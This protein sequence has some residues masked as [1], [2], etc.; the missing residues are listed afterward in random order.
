LIRFIKKLFLPVAAPSGGIVAQRPLAGATPD[1]FHHSRR[2][3]FSFFGVG[4]VMLAKPDLFLPNRPSSVKEIRFE[5]EI[6][7]PLTAGL[8]K[9]F[10]ETYARRY[11]ALE[12]ALFFEIITGVVPPEAL[13]PVPAPDKNGMVYGFWPDEIVPAR[14]SLDDPWEG[15]LHMVL[16]G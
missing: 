7:G 2:K 12:E 5:P 16:D 13:P 8:R 14:W 9:E 3:F 6:S 11:A 10:M 4:A 1:G 15:N